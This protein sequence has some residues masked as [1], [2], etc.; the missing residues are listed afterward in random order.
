MFKRI[1]HKLLCPPDSDTLRLPVIN[2]ITKPEVK[3]VFTFSTLLDFNEITLHKHTFTYIERRCPHCG[4]LLD[5]QER[6]NTTSTIISIDLVTQ[7]DLFN[8]LLMVDNTF[9]S[10]EVSLII[11]ELFDIE[12]M[13]FRS[14]WKNC[15]KKIMNLSD[16]QLDL[17]LESNKDYTNSVVSCIQNILKE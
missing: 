12:K 9:T 16:A 15:L 8:Y 6:R 7:V 17:L 14:D 2:I 13:E 4:L 1:F 10:D 3:P 11:L 5:T